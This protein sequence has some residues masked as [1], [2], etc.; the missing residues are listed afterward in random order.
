MKLYLDDYRPAPDGWTLAKDIIDAK[1]LLA[2]GR[3]E[4]ASLDHDLGACETCLDGKTAEQWI[5][6]NNYQSAPHCEHVGTGYELCVWM[7]DTGWWP[8]T[9]PTVHSLNPVGRERMIGVISHYFLEPDAAKAWREQRARELTGEM[10][11]R[12]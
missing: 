4:E 6:E 5:V 3:V 1:H 9:M 11:V 8:Q 2:T 12:P 7:A 10:E